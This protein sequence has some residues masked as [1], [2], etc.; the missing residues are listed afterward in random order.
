MQKEIDN[1]WE[2]AAKHKEDIQSSMKQPK[3]VAVSAGSGRSIEEL[4]KDEVAQIH[5]RVRHG[6]DSTTGQLNHLRGQLEEQLATVAGE[7]K[8]DNQNIRQDIKV[9]IRDFKDENYQPQHEAAEDYQLATP[10]NG[11]ARSPEGISSA[12]SPETIM[13]NLKEFQDKITKDLNDFMI[14]KHRGT[15]GNEKAEHG[16]E[17]RCGPAEF[18]WRPKPLNALEKM[19]VE[20]PCSRQTPRWDAPPGGVKAANQQRAEPFRYGC[21]DQ[22]LSNITNEPIKFVPQR[23]M[24]EWKANAAECVQMAQP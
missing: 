24:K 5:N 20:T 14:T 19:N 17:Q 3:G 8:E 11:G 22:T 16:K 21:K 2:L 13:D 4:L 9:Y 10:V 15:A 1:H 18:D 7:A 23:N 6:T 12:P